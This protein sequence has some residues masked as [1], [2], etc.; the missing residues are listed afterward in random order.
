M[1]SGREGRICE[2]PKMIGWSVSQA[3]APEMGISEEGAAS[4]QREGTVVDYWVGSGLLP[5]LG[6][7]V[8]LLVSVRIRCVSAT[9][10]LCI[11]VDALSRS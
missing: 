10:Q 11:S 8:T 6:Q 7:F 1:N 4:S 5:F 9:Y 2:S 3:G